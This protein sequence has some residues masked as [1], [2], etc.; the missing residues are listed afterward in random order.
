MN[1]LSHYYL[2]QSSNDPYLILGTVLPDLFRVGDR[3]RRMPEQAIDFFSQAS[4]SALQ[5][6]VNKHHLID[7]LFHNALF[8]HKYSQA[9]SK[10]LRSAELVGM[11][12]FQHFYGH[13]LLE[14]LIDKSLLN[15][16]PELVTS[17]YELLH[18]VDL[19]EVNEFLKLKGLDEHF[20]S[21]AEQFQAFLHYRYLE[22]YLNPGGVVLAM[23]KI[24]KKM[25]RYDLS[26]SSDQAK[27]QEV[28]D[29]GMVLIKEDYPKI[30]SKLE[31]LCERDEIS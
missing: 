25:H 28:V 1:Y 4:H 11:P 19:N 27:L 6:G 5:K 8:F 12:R 10:L 2:D 13:I 14:I 9:I 7:R 30:F 22:H 18:Q 23:T 26:A 16:Q 31:A 29:A 21:F 15:E 20:D 17:F 3:K 24:A